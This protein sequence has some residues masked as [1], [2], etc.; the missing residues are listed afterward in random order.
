MFA[1][2]HPSTPRI[3]PGTPRPVSV[4]TADAS[5]SAGAAE[6]SVRRHAPEVPAGCRVRADLHVVALDASG[7][8][9]TVIGGG[10]DRAATSLVEGADLIALTSSGDRGLVAELVSATA[11]TGGWLEAIIELDLGTGPRPVILSA[12]SVPWLGRGQCALA[13]VRPTAGEEPRQ[14]PEERLRRVGPPF[15]VPPTPPSTP[16]AGAPGLIPVRPVPSSEST[17]DSDPEVAGLVVHTDPMTRLVARHRLEDL[18]VRVLAAASA[19]DALAL[20]SAPS[21]LRPVDLVLIEVG[22]VR[23]RPDWAS[24]VRAMP[25]RR[26]VPLIG[27]VASPPAAESEPADKHGLDE[28]IVG[29][30]SEA[31]LRGVLARLHSRRVNRGRGR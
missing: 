10:A 18:G 24:R 1:F 25:H 15:L 29:P 7:R 30:G 5:A 22:L 20:L 12:T 13:T 17:S 21:A 3:E 6:A 9:V 28:I 14:P 16:V 31:N 26:A 23:D 2:V 4:A 11:R 27:L 8:V 19:K